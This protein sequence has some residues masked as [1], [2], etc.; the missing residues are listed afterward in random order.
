MTAE[1]HRVR[2]G[3]HTIE[4]AVV[5]RERTTLEI[6]VEPDTT[7]V[8]A[9]PLNASLEAIAE[10]VRKRAA[11]VRRQ[12]RF[13]ASVF[14]PDTGAAFRGWGNPSLSRTA[15]P[16]ESGSPRAGGGQADPWLYPC[17]ES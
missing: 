8:V 9:A 3:A 5:R 14:A 7:V 15:V 10:K 1:R 6:G 2:Y 17:P 13:F 12:Q 11:W 4:F 16:P